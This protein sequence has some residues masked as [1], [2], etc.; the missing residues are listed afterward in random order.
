MDIV[1]N[2]EAPESAV[3]PEIR[4]ADLGNER[5]LDEDTVVQIIL[6]PPLLNNISDCPSSVWQYYCTYL[7]DIVDIAA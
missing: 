5:G 2:W 4:T 1:R 6:Q 3:I 7:T